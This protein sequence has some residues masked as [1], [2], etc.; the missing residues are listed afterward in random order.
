MIEESREQKLARRAVDARILET[1][2]AHWEKRYRKSV[3]AGELMSIGN[4]A[5][6]RIVKRYEDELGA[7]EDYCRRLVDFAMLTGIRVEA[8]VKRIDWAAQLATADLLALRRTEPGASPR[9]SARALVRAVAAATFAAMTEEAQ[10]GGEGDMIAREDFA[11]AMR[12][13]A[14]MLTAAPRSKRELFVL[15]YGG[16]HTLVDAQKVLGFH[17]NTLRGWHQNML[18]EIRRELEKR[19]ITHA[20]SRG[21]APRVALAVLRGED[22]GQGKED[23]GEGEDDPSR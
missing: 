22:D 21:G 20:P 12:V 17:Y 18:A 23:D 7:F 15:L 6:P 9:E 4:S 2:S 19:D 16:R 13:I 10:R 14:A 5:L 8:R 1:R 11:T 3:D